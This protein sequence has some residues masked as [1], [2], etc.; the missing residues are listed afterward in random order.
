M[1]SGV[2]RPLPLAHLLGKYR[3]NR[4]GQALLEPTLTAPPFVQVSQFHAPQDER[5]TLPK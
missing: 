1:L 5:L 3:R 4:L 2:Q